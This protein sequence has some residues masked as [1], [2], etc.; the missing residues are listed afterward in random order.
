MRYIK[1]FEKL[2]NNLID[3]V[4]ANNIKAIEELINDGVNLNETDHKGDT[5][6]N[7]A[8]SYG[9]AHIIKLLID[10]GADVNKQNNNGKTAL[11]FATTFYN[12]N[13]NSNLGSYMHLFKVLID[14]GSNWNI[15]DKNGKDFFD[16]LLNDN[17]RKVIIELY[18]DKYEEY[19]IKKDAKKYNL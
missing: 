11:I 16:Y 14:G 10:G 8:A 5:P 17:A 9:L 6:L 15:K 18:P 7:W 12:K 3:Y 13:Y 2:D 1:K 4:R 19:L